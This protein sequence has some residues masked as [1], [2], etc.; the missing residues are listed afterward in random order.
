MNNRN[1]QL[2]Q[3][4]M[5]IFKKSISSDARAHLTEAEFSKLAQ[6]VLEAL[7]L[8][9]TE[10]VEMIDEL[11]RRLRERTGRREIDL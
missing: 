7:E 4:V 3:N 9:M 8:E 10:A 6:I 5:E 1:E 2:A 11:E